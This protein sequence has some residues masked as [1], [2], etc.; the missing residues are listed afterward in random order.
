MFFFG[1]GFGNHIVHVHLDF[2]MHYIV[3]QSPHRL[4]IGCP[5]VLEPEGHHL[6]TEC[7]PQGDERHFFHVL[8]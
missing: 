4:L 1:F 6:V 5:D 8:W 7:S 3:E 2:L